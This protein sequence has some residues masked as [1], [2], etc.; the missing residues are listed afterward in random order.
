MYQ[1]TQIIGH[2]GKDVTMRYTAD[3]KA[4]ADFTV[5]INSGFG[6]TKS[7]AWFKVTAWEKTAENCNQYLAKGS[8]VFISGRLAFDEKTGG[9]KTWVGK[10]DNTVHTSFEVT[11]DRVVFLDSRGDKVAE[12]MQADEVKELK[13]EV[14]F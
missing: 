6:D 12:T 11:A 1:Q 2:L 9:P 13:D 7:T 10:E 4:V 14:S 5:A 8:K 3:G